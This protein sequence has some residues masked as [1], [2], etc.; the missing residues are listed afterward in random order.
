MAPIITS[1]ILPSLTLC[2][3]P[4]SERGVLDEFL[5]GT[6]RR[7]QCSGLSDLYD[8]IVDQTMCTDDLILESPYAASNDNITDYT[9][10]DPDSFADIREEYA[11]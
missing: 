1:S 6:S 4:L 2:L 7:A 9:A 10:T 11:K 5:T 8:D 3:L